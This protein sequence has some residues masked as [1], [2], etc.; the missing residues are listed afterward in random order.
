MTDNPEMEILVEG[1]VVQKT[2]YLYTA[3]GFTTPVLCRADTYDEYVCKE[4]QRSYGKLDVDGKVFIDIGANIGAFSVWAMDHGATGGHAFEPEPRNFKM[5]EW[6]VQGFE[7]VS[8]MEYALDSN[9]TGTGCD[10]YVAKSGINPG[11]TS[12]RKIR[13]RESFSV[14]TF[15]FQTLLEDSSA[16]VVKM[17][18]EGAEFDLL[19]FIQDSRITQIAFELHLQGANDNGRLMDQARRVPTMFASWDCVVEPR[20]DKETLWHTLAVYRR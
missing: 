13:G 7:N 14:N 2:T 5:L 19:P 20:L 9:P 17:D 11:N 12:T 18:C 15:N 10:L 6:N 3:K 1:E 4:I 8:P 16:T